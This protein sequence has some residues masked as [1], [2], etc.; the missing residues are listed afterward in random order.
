MMI[1]GDG[2]QCFWDLELRIFEELFSISKA[3]FGI[4]GGKLLPNLKSF[5]D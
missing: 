4:L 1:V 5:G 3:S 2:K